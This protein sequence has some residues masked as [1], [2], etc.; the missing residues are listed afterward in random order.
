MKSFSTAQVDL[1]LVLISLPVVSCSGEARQLGTTTTSN[2]MP[3]ASVLN[4][5]DAGEPRDFSVADGS[6]T[7]PRVDPPEVPL[8]L[9][10]G[11]VWVGYGIGAPPNQQLDS[12]HLSSHAYGACADLGGVPGE[13]LLVAEDDEARIECCTD[14]APLASPEQDSVSDVDS[15]VNTSSDGNTRQALVAEAS[16][17]CS[18]TGQQLGDWVAVYTEDGV[19]VERLHFECG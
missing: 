12:Q 14:G 16:A 1:L 18:E 13:Q 5:L 3:T 9:G 11:C 7:R 2:S 19:T 4:P 8:S 10:P 15:V 17:M 6:V